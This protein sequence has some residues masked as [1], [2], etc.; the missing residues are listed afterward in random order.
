MDPDVVIDCVTT[1]VNKSE[2]YSPSRKSKVLKSKQQT[3]KDQEI[4][5]YN[6]T[7]PTLVC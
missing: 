5:D 3:M 6:A 7:L 2:K 4:H 1:W